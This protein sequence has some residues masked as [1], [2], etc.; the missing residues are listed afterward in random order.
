M[1]ACIWLKSVHAGKALRESE[2]RQAFLLKLSD[3][4]R[5]LAAAADIHGETTRLLR[6]QL[7]AGWCYYVDWDLCRKTGL[8]LRDSV[9][10]GLPSLVGSHDVSDAPEFLELL[11]DGEVHSARDYANYEQLPI[12]IRQNFTALGFRSMMMAPLI[13]GGRLIA[14]LLVGDTEVRD[15][16]S[17]EASILV[18]TAERTLAAIERGRAEAALRE[19]REALASDLANAELLRSLSERLVPEDS[20]Q[21]IYD[22]AL[23]AT[24]SITSADA[25]TFQL[26]D[27]ATKT[28][29]LIASRNFSKTITDY[30]DRVDAG[31]RTACGIALKTGE[32]AFAD[33]PE[34]VG[35][36]GCRLLVGEG[37][38]SAVAYPL[39]SRAGA[40]LGMLNALWHRARH[41]LSEREVRFLGLLARQAADLIERWRNQTA[42]RESEER[43][44]SMA[45]A[46]EDVFY[47]TV[48]RAGFVGGPH[49]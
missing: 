6:S 35:D 32:L 20:L 40:P 46:I 24:I 26:F 36:V 7:N 41:R 9:R 33:F 39:M 3:A 48:N 25:G 16:S 30:F 12:S 29:E 31:S 37:I 22:E 27:P 15:W 17:G 18:E 8:V 44:C 28:L 11:S 10:E 2:E 34:E 23:S 42:L 1:I 45:Q 49:S 47:V 13:K 38:Q 43:F 4:V 19:S 21:S 5:P 14:T